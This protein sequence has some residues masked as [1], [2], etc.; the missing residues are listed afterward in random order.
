MCA[1]EFS[2][3]RPCGAG[4]SAA[5]LYCGMPAV[6]VIPSFIAF[7]VAFDF[8]LSS[9]AF[10]V[11]VSVATFAAALISSR[12]KRAKK[13]LFAVLLAVAHSALLLT[14]GK[15]GLL[16]VTIWAMLGTG[17]FVASVCFL[18]PVFIKKLKYNFLETELVSGAVLLIC[19]STGLCG[20]RIGG[21]DAAYLLTAFFIPFA[22]AIGSLSGAVAVGMCF[23][24]GI[25]VFTLSPLPIA[26][27]AFSALV[28]SVFAR[29]PRPLPSLSAAA[30][31]ILV[32]YLFAAPPSWQQTVCFAAGSLIF[33]L[34]P[35]RLLDRVRDTLFA[36]VTAAAARGV[37]G[38]VAS[39]T[40]NSLL[41]AS[42]IFDDMKTAME[43]VPDYEGESVLE[44]KVCSRCGRYQ[45]CSAVEGFG[46]ALCK[47]EHA[48]AV[49]GRASVSEIPAILSMCDNLSA[50]VAGATDAAQTRHAQH[51]AAEAKR[52]GRKIVAQ[53]LGLMSGVLRQL[54]ERVKTP[55]RFDVESERRIAAEL[56][57]RGAAVPEVIVTADTVSVVM[58]SDDIGSDA[59]AEAVG[60]VMRAPYRFIRGSADVL[61]G[62]T[63]MVFGRAPRYDVAFSVASVAKEGR[64]G[65][66]HS[67]IHLGGDRFMMALCDGM[68]SG[69]EAEK[70]SETAIELVESF[71]KA[72]LGSVS[73]VECVNRFLALNECERFSTLDITVIDLNSGDAEII[74]LSSPATVIKSSDGVCAVSGSALPMGVLE[75]VKCGRVAKVLKAGDEIIMATDGVTEALG[76]TEKFVTA[77]AMQNT[78]DPQIE[79]KNILECAVAMQN[80]KLRDDGTVLCAR[81]FEK[82]CGA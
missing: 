69:E 15:R 40:G 22:A 64:S 74:K 8:S 46:E 60:R 56:A 57:Y 61:P 27:T 48:S 81:I 68:G 75:N 14:S 2:G 38:R 10:S 76:S 54:G 17:I 67:F 52:E 71:F 65:D 51:I 42:R 44:R 13:P 6:V 34:L 73:A 80:G 41:G 23:G 62:Y 26:F 72:G 36:P 59:A 35:P 70:A 33:A 18:T 79:A 63:M 21:F 19:A 1:A 12:F 78:A 5:L 9:L 30:A 53:Q 37:I 28:T 43:Q 45:V 49:K 25:A 58:R 66:N 55:A 20:M 29:A 31:Y 82:N 47:M 32:S 39:E 4:Y 16:P 24:C 11:S 7:S 77:A 50:L 3:L